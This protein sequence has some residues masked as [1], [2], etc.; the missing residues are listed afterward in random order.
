M[1]SKLKRKGG[2][3]TTAFQITYEGVVVKA[4]P[5][6][7]TDDL[8]LQSPF[9]QAKTL[10]LPCVKQSSSDPVILW[11]LYRLQADEGKETLQERYEAFKEWGR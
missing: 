3:E 2:N 6:L 8:I 10:N 9:T 1:L 7:Y 4:G 5:A 11:Q